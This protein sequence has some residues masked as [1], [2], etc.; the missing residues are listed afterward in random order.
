ML[1]S[2]TATATADT[3]RR[4]ITVTAV[5]DAKIYDG[6]TSSTGVPTIT[7]GS[8]ATGDTAAWT[9]AFDSKD[10]VTAHTLIPAG[11]VNDGN[12]GSNYSVTFA[13][14]TT[15]TISAKALTV[16]GITANNK[17]YDNN[18]AATLNVG[19]ATLVG[20]IGSDL[21][22]KLETYLRELLETARRPAES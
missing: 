12:A 10:V 1:A 22:R 3:T 11:S 13:N 5:E 8:L 4:P 16:T 19:S 20:V 2:S 6:T 15:G 17:V 14:F 18:T 9:Q 7:A 21:E